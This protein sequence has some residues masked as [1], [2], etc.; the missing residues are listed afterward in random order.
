MFGWGPIKSGALVLFIF[1]GN[2]AIKPA[3][4]FLYGSCGFRRVLLASS[5]CLSLTAIGCGPFTAS[6]PLVAIALLTLISGVAR[7]VSMTSY[8]SLA[9]SDVVPR[10][11]PRTRCSAR[12]SS[13]SPAWP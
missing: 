11:V 7:S 6:T 1:V 10:C 2:I 4:S 8:T 5:I 9:L 13:C 3:T 12:P